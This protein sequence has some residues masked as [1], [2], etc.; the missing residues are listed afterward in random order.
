MLTKLRIEGF[1]SWRDSGTLRL[2]PI[3]GLFGP[4][5]SGK[6][7][8]LQFL[9][10]LKQTAESVDTRQVFDLGDEK[11]Y[12]DLGRFRDVLFQG[13]QRHA[14]ELRTSIEWHLPPV[15]HLKLALGER[16][17]AGTQAVSFDGVYGVDDRGGPVTFESAY[18]LGDAALSI[19]RDRHAGNDRASFDAVLS[20]S[21]H[22]TV[23]SL[24]ARY[25]FPFY[26]TPMG[27]TD[28]GPEFGR[29][30]RLLT[31]ID[32][33]F[34]SVLGEIRYLGPLRDFPRR[35]Y[36]WGGSAPFDVGRHGELAV[37]ALLASSAPGTPG[38]SHVQS[39]VARW[40]K[41]LNLIADFS[42]EEIGEGAGL[43]RAWVRRAPGSCRVPLTDIGF[44]VS[45][46]L[47][48]VTL[49]FYAPR[50][51]TVILEQPELHL[52]P[53]VQAGLADLLIE[54]A[55]T[56]GLQIIVE[57]HSEHLLRRLQLR[58]AEESLSPAD[59]ALYFCEFVG[60]ES[61]ATELQLD[62]LGNITNWP[63]DF[64]G[65]EFG[66]MAAMTRAQVA[67]KRRNPS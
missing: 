17:A 9:L 58:I 30:G 41:E 56:R 6:S 20:V 57:S 7:S 63:Q 64:F 15:E 18:R 38:R 26:A 42:I 49:C 16:K 54:A 40:L 48:V 66:E 52:H 43:Y 55:K 51:S 3:T 33:I 28:P 39:D 10:M 65:D 27:M 62:E 2:S 53:S 50:G 60:D 8:I 31:H 4:N 24:Q 32:A 34:A 35:Q 46:V 67:R 13:A 23:G 44:G 5:S 59:A 36:I 21:G 1:K 61:R 12:I 47:P 14:A 37:A 45:Q 29:Y 19:R 11:S 25:A 22:K